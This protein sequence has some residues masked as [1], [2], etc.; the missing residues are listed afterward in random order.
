MA[1]TNLPM[2]T[3]RG[4]TSPDGQYEW[5]GNEWELRRNNVDN[6]I[7]FPVSLSDVIT[8][9]IPIAN[10]SGNLIHNTLQRVTLI[11]SANGAAITLAAPLPAN[12]YI[13]SGSSFLPRTALAIGDQL[14]ITNANPAGYNG[15]YTVA[16]VQGNTIFTSRDTNSLTGF[17]SGS[18]FIR[19]RISGSW[20]QYRFNG[21]SN[22]YRVINSRTGLSTLERSQPSLA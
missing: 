13:P 11:T 3:I 21:D 2:G 8:G 19:E 12:F 18:L 6:P 9:N 1:S 4:Q 7:D 16:S 5:N 20:L 10:G 17:N 14:L 22:W 15:L